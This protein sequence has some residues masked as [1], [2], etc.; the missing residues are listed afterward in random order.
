[1]SDLAE[2]AAAIRRFNEERDWARFHD[3][4]S[5]TLALVGEVGE[6]AELLQWVPAVSVREDVRAGTLHDRVAEELSDILIYLLN[7]A[8]QA[9]VDLASAATAKLAA[10][11]RKYPVN[12]FA[13]RAPTRS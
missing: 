4:K 13:G 12:D 7:I 10:A 9:D 2:L 1:M 8:E 3:P 11:G 6:L 5:L